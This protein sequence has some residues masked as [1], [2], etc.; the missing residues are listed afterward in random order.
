MCE[1]DREKGAGDAHRAVYLPLR[2]MHTTT[3]PS[4]AATITSFMVPVLVF[5]SSSSESL[6]LLWSLSPLAEASY[7]YTGWPGTHSAPAEEE[8]P[9]FRGTQRFFRCLSGNQKLLLFFF[10]P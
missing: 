10:F 8:G 6:L 3:N 4:K 5:F 1:E 7:I 2:P 9:E